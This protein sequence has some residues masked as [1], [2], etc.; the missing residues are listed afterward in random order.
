MPIKYSKD[1]TSLSER[2]NDAIGWLD[3]ALLDF[4]EGKTQSVSGNE[5][6]TRLQTAM[7]LLAGLQNDINDLETLVAGADKTDDQD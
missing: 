2:L 6:A 3:F 4:I 1:R 5:N 7:R